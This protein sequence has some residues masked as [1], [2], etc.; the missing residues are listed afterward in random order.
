MGDLAATPWA[1]HRGLLVDAQPGVPVAAAPWR[2]SGATIGVAGPAALPGAHNRAVLAELGY[3][4]DEI[5][6]LVAGGG[7]PIVLSGYRVGRR[8]F[9]MAKA[10]AVRYRAAAGR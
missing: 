1:A 2:S 5:D 3:G 9:A 10:G 6:A 4:P 8:S 7:R